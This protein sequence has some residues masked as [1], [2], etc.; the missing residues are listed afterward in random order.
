MC[1]TNPIKEGS[2]DAYSRFHRFKVRIHI[3]GA[4]RRRLIKIDKHVV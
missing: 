3:K 1:A 2:K 4:E